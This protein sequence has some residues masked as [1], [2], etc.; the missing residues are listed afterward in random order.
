MITK[1]IPIQNKLGLHARAASVFVKTA[2]AFASEITI[3]NPAKQAD[4]KSIMSVMLLEATKGTEVTLTT[5]GAD[6]TDA[7]AALEALIN[8]KFGEDE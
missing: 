3:A 1:S 8:N 5:S 7:M 4:G 2:Q 6:E